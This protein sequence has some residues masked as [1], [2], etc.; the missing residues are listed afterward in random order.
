LIQARA[1]SI[2]VPVAGASAAAV[3][4]PAAKLGPEPTQDAGGELVY[5]MTAE[6]TV[7]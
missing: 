2:N 1:V 7:E 3:R 6:T 5:S 4:A